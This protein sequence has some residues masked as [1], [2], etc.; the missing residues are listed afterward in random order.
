MNHLGELPLDGHP[1]HHRIQAI[2]GF[3]QNAVRSGKTDAHMPACAGPEP[4]WRS[5]NQ[6]HARVFTQVP[7]K[8]F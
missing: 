2:K 1:G 5:G 8:V 7:A 3:L 6:G 4:S